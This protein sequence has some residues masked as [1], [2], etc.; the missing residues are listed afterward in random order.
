MGKEELENSE[1]KHTYASLKGSN[2]RLR[3]AMAF[4]GNDT[5]FLQ[6]PNLEPTKSFG[7]KWLEIFDSYNYP[8]QKPSMDNTGKMLIVVEA[9]IHRVSLYYFFTF[10]NVWNF[11]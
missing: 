3:M 2:H 1:N 9:E 10:L 5:K 11:M 6:L 4:R 7:L 8:T